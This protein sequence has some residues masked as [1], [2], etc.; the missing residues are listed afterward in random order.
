MRAIYFP[1]NKGSV[2]GAVF[3][4]V[5]FKAQNTLFLFVFRP[6]FVTTVQIEKAR[7]R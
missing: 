1:I 5:F 6:F 3:W 2:L 4:E 7:N